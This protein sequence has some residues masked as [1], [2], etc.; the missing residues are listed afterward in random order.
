MANQVNY[1]SEIQT[2]EIIQAVHVN[3]FVYAL[4][5][6]QAYDLNISGSLTLT[7]SVDS[8]N[9]YT[10]SL[11]GTASYADKGIT[12]RTTNL[13]VNNLN[14]W[15]TFVS[16]T[17]I[18][19]SGVSS[20]TQLVVDSG[21]DGSGLSYNPSNNSLSASIFVGDLE[22]TSSYSTVSTTFEE[23]VTGSYNGTTIYPQGTIYTKFENIF[24]SQSSVEEYDLLAA[25]TRFTGDR[26]LPPVYCQ[27]TTLTDAKIVKFN[28]KGFCGGNAAGGPNATL[29]SY[30]KI[31]NT[32]LTGTQLGQGGAISLNQV[33]DVPFE[34]EYEIV[35]SNDQIYGCGA[36]GW[37][38][39]EDFK[40]YALSNLYVPIPNT[41]VDG[42]LQF[43]VSGS[44][45]ISI[46]G[47][48]AYVEFIN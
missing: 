14:Y 48:V 7:G 47:S 5:G 36:I 29:D 28:L 3:Q 34:I 18:G 35:F 21:S 26:N 37:C 39:G 44:S 16:P 45:D 4:T 46:T 20:F 27:Q 40:R 23:Y 38:K 6:S 32:I 12:V 41:A 9:G 8:L 43:I 15:L 22:G 1:L 42:N 11:N 13:P 33:D 31:G 19:E 24:A 2:G 10:G 25:I 30:V 17:D